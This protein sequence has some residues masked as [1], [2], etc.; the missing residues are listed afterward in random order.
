MPPSGAIP[1]RFLLANRDLAFQVPLLVDVLV[2]FVLINIVLMIFNL[3]PIPPLDGSKVLFAFLDRRTEYQVR[4]ILEQ[5]GFFI[6]IA[7]LFLPP[8]NPILSSVIGPVID[9]VFGFL[10]GF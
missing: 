2:L 4:P 9:G 5:Y 10:V 7:L 3:I 6:L 1:L 8:G